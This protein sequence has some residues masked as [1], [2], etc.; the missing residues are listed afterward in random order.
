MADWYHN[1]GNGTSTGYYAVA[2]WAAAHTYGAG[3]I[4]RQLAAPSVGNERCFRT[5]AGGISSAVE[6]TW[7]LTKGSSSPT[8][9]TVTDW[10]EVTGNSTYSWTAPHARAATAASFM[11]AG[12]NLYTSSAS[13]ETQASTTTITF[14]GVNSNL[15]RWMSV[16]TTNTPPT[17]TD[18][19][20]GASVTTTGTSTLA[21]A[22]PVAI[23]GVT[24]NCGT[25]S[26]A[27]NLTLGAT[28]LRQLYD[29]CAFALVTTGNATLTI[30]NNIEFVNTSVSFAAVGQKIFSAAGI[31]VW[32]D[33][34]APISSATIPTSLL[35][36]S[37]NTSN[38]LLKGL[39]FSAM[40]S[41]KNLI[42]IP[43]ANAGVRNIQAIN[44]RLGA[45]ANFVSGA[46][47]SWSTFADLIITDSG[48]TGYRQ[49][50][51]W[52]QGTLTTDTVVVLTGGASDGT[53]PISW[54]VA[55]TANNKRFI[56]FECFEIVQWNS[57][58]GSS[59]TATIQFL[60]DTATDATLTNADVWI[61]AHVLNNASY[62]LAALVTSAPAN[63]LTTGT[64]LTAGVGTSS[65]VTTGI[66][67]PNSQQVSVTF[68]QQIPGYVRFVVKVG[69]ASLATL[70]VNPLVAIV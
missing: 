38:I 67:T 45:S 48:A 18:V 61:E 49:E 36:I 20:A 54:K 4:V 13:A 22:G 26:T 62:P 65:W 66:T 28:C 40:G 55:S 15:C 33:T 42:A 19:L 34:A 14:P 53:T 16:G 44:C 31:L 21:N 52:Y 17:G 3:S 10:L 43:G 57:V 58:V 50:R 25:G 47:T 60:T 24:F 27:A 12:D 51:Y 35:D 30:N 68:T 8:D 2:Q 6:P 70:R 41:G 59:K 56:P 7:V 37:A 29:T 69:R 32:R 64:T 9:G 46:A 23:Y 63:Q 39:D 11:A 5:A 1:Y